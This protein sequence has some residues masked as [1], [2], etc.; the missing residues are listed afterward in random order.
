MEKIRTL[1]VAL[2]LMAAACAPAVPPSPSP[3]APT[4]TPAPVRV[5]RVAIL[6]DI[7]NLEPGFL[8]SRWDDMVMKAL[9]SNLFA[10]KPGTFEI[11]PDAVESYEVSEDGLE[12]TFKLREGIK[13]HR[14]YGELTTEDVKYTY[15]LI[16]NPESGS[17]YQGDWAALD[18]VE[19]IDKYTGK[20]ILKEPFAPLWSTTLPATSGM[21]MCRKAREELGDKH[22][23]SPVG[24]GPYELVEWVPKQRVVLRRFKDYYGEPPY[25]DEIHLFPLEDEAAAEI[26]LEAGEIDWTV[27]SIPAM[28]RFEKDER[29]GVGSAISLGYTWVG[30]NVENPKLRDVRVRK[31]I[32]SAIDVDAIIKAVYFGRVERAKG[33]IAPTLLG[34]WSE[35]PLRTR[36]VEEAKRYL[37]EAGVE[38]LDLTLAIES[39]T[40]MRAIAEIV[41]ANL[42]EVGINVEINAMDSATFWEIGFGDKGKEVELFV[43]AYSMEPDPSWATMWFTCDQV[44]Q[45]NWQRWCNPRFDELHLQA[46]RTLNPEERARMYIEMQKLMDEDAIAVWIT[47]GLVPYAYIK[48]LNPVLTP[49][50]YA[51]FAR[52]TGP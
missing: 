17:P 38:T 39:T 51:L 37:K 18:R 12:I 28:E 50:G 47:H 30:M 26:A 20:I 44:G 27:I 21:I 22:V 14:G 42:K 16:A 35:A 19:I 33:L 49:H 24:S 43:N 6:D 10:F 34:H 1:L 8:V 36:D 32:R 52:F 5:L 4:P 3:L 23:T 29:F 11:I 31:A 40:E 48:G 2:I 15:E 9:Y 13:W 41:Q 7:A 46:L 45:W 25:Y